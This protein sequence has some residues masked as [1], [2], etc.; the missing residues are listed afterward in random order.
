MWTLSAI[1]M[2]RIMVVACAETGSS[3]TPFHPAIPMAKAVDKTMTA[4]VATVAATDLSSSTKTTISTRYMT[5]T[6]VFM[7]LSPA[8]MKAL[9]SIETP[10][11]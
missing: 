6:T 8:S 9:L 11:R 3:S 10:V 5:G 4:A 1:A 2:V 7:S